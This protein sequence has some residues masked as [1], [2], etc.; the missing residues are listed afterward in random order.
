MKMFTC[1]LLVLASVCQAQTFKPNYSED[2]V[3]KYTLPDLLKSPNNTVIKTK[4]QWKDI[5]RPEILKLF[6]DNVYGQL[7]RDFDSL[8]FAVT[9]QNDAAMNGKAT[10]KEVKI[11]VYRNAQSVVINLTLFVPKTTTTP[12][13]VFLLIN[14]REKEVANP[15]RQTKSEFW[16]AELVIDSGYAVA[17]FQVSDLA[18]DDED[19]FAIGVLRLYP[20]QL[21]A[22]NGMRAIGAWAWGASRIMDYFEKD[23]DINA[24]Q[25][26]LVGHSRGG[27]TSLWASAQDQRF[28]MCVANNSGNTGA[29][30][31]RRRLG[32]TIEAINNMFP[33]WFT[34]N[35]K[36]YNRNEDAL[37]V[38]QHMLLALTAPRPLYTT[39]ATEDMWADP[40]GS[41]L[42]VK[43]AEKVYRLFGAKTNLPANIPEKNKP[44]IQKP[45]GY[46]LREGKHDMTIYD[47]KNFIRLANLSFR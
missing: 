36:K 41:Y 28:A 44:V 31:S 12:A 14:N 21:K 35:Y 20:E 25:V 23:N 16:P 3:P 7:P 46:H 8:S 40:K 5:R 1:M 10:L 13:P 11:S 47:W 4:E 9:N 32:E 26:V 45:L 17:S 27:K 43:E 39:S 6:E 24:T 18:P 2:K 33:H 37:P 29:A 30:L 34:T 22:D 15:T 38:D 42:S 19:S